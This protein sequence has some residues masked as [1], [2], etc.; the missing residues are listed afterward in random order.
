MAVWDFWLRF[1]ETELCQVLDTVF[2]FSKHGIEVWC[3]TGDERAYGRLSELIAPLRSSLEIAVYATLLSAEKKPPEDTDPPPSL[4][5]NSELRAYLQDPFLRFNG[6]PSPEA[7]SAG[8]NADGGQGRENPAMS[9][10]K[11]RM[12][13]FANQILDWARRME[14]C[15]ADLPALVHV[16]L[17]SAEPKEIHSRATT[18]CLAHAEAVDRYAAKLG[19][20]LSQAL[21]KGTR[22]GLTSSKPELPRS[23]S[24]PAELAVQAA[25]SAEDLARRIYHFIYPVHFMVG[26]A[27]LREPDLLGSLDQLRKL[28]STLRR[29]L[30]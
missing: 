14:R 5:N 21:P 11:L 8:R 29:T 13:S 2:V 12:I 15:A 6:F 23:S 9:A 20:N 28:V 10:F 7:G 4:W 27:D 3:R 24:Q 1:H 16:T 22:R 17:S 19:E 25:G 26:L 30:R 18:I